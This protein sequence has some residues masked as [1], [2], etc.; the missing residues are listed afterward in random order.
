MQTQIKMNFRLHLLFSLFIALIVGM[1][2]LG[3][4]IVNFYF[5]NTSVAVFMAPLTF[6]ITDIVEEVYGKKI[7]GNF[8]IG[9][10]VAL[11]VVLVYVQ[12]FVSLEPA[13]RFASNNDAYVAIFRNSPR[14]ILASL[15]A[16]LLSQFHDMVAFDFWKRKTGGKALWLRNNLSTIVSQLID[17]T[18]YMM[19]AFYKI[20]PQ[21]TLSFI[22][23]LIIP[24]FLLKLVFAILD[25][26]FVY[27]GVRWLRHGE[28]KAYYG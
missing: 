27:L 2:L 12:I 11:V 9:A 22:I 25:T 18:L 14:L 3:I 5:I 6:L 21:F 20:T 10:A 15:L 17:T 7:V 1:N 16:F 28:R 13:S 8:I 23:S 26:P 24:Y 19:L 4:K